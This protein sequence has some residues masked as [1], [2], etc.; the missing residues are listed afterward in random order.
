[1][2]DRCLVRD[3]SALSQLYNDCHASVQ[4]AIRTVLGNDSRRIDKVSARVWQS[5]IRNDFEL[6]NG[7]DGQGACRLTTYVS[8]LASAEARRFLVQEPPHVSAVNAISQHQAQQRLAIHGERS[9]RERH[10]H[11]PAHQAGH[12]SSTLAA[13]A[14]DRLTADVLLVDLHT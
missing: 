14:A 5:L 3:V 12:R 2:V 11:E 1:L 4:A 10:P 13:T 9:S 6:L 8:V 7:F